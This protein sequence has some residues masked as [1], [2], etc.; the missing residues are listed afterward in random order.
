MAC[1][2]LSRNA[3]SSGKSTP[4]AWH[5]LSLERIAVNVD[6]PRQN[7]E[8]GRVDPLLRGIVAVDGA[9][10]AAGGIHMNACSLETAVNKRVSAF[11]ADL[12]DLFSVGG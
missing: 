7:Q 4:R 3:T 10:G 1:R 9:N 6:N 2:S 8:A 5:H 12:H 11:D